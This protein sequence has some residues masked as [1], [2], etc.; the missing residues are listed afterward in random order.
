MKIGFKFL[1]I[2]IFIL[3][4]FNQSNLFAD[5]KKFCTPTLEI[6]PPPWENFLVHDDIF[7]PWNDILLDSILAP[8][9]SIISCT[10]VDVNT[11]LKQNG[12]EDTRY[13]WK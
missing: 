12:V 10:K 1:N 9:N 11:Y 8:W 6:D 4:F 3:F 7:A 5:H 13:Y 2:L